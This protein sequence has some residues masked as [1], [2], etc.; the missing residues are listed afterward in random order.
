MQITQGM[1]EEA[2][3]QHNLKYVPAL[4]VTVIR[5]LAISRGQL[6]T[7]GDA[8]YIY[9]YLFLCSKYTKFNL[10]QLIICF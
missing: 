2:R 10:S 7:K 8:V 6:L 5:M 9:S 4:A 1:Q 3:M